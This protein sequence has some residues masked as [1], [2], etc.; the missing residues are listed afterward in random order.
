MPKSAGVNAD[1]SSADSNGNE[2]TGM[3]VCRQYE[4]VLLWVSGQNAGLHV[5]VYVNANE[6][7]GSNYSWY[8]GVLRVLSFNVFNIKILKFLKN[9]NF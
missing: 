3:V 8:Y 5:N 1:L 4:F 9:Y 2:S 6:G 7:Y